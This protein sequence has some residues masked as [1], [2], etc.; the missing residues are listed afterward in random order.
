MLAVHQLILCSY[1]GH[2]YVGI[3]PLSRL[4]NS[5]VR[6]AAIPCVRCLNACI[7]ILLLGIC[8]QKASADQFE[9]PRMLILGDSNIFESFGKEL[10]ADFQAAGFIVKRRGKPTS[11]MARLTSSIG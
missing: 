4:S 3:A 8:A 6:Q 1:R 11:G 2:H 9:R 10:E 5:L 7:A